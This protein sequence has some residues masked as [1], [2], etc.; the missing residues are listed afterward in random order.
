MDVDLYLDLAD[1]LPVVERESN[2]EG[3]VDATA[4]GD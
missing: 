4:A 1:E 2:V 3:C